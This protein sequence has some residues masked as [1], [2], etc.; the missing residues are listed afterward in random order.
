MKWIKEMKLKDDI[1]KLEEIQKRKIELNLNREVATTY[2]QR[3]TR[4]NQ[5]KALE[6]KK[7]ELINSKIRDE[8]KKQE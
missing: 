5:L 4:I 8:K 3:R 6:H 2:L 1:E 7:K